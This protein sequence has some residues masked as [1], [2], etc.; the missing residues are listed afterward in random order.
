MIP[1]I[2]KQTAI[3]LKLLTAPVSTWSP[4]ATA[5]N[6]RPG[7]KLNL[8]LIKDNAGL[9]GIPELRSHE[10]FYAM[11]ERAIWETDKLVTE[12]CSPNRTRKL[13]EIFDELSD[14]LCKVADLAEFVRIAHPQAAYSQAAE[15]ACVSISGIVE[16]LNTHQ[17]LY[18]TLRTGVDAGDKIPMSPVDQHVARLFLFDFEQSGIHL[19]ETDRRRVVA[20]NDSILQLGQR[21]ITGAVSPR[22]IPKDSLPPNLRQF[23]SVD[24]D[25]VL[26]T[27]LYADSP[28][29]MAREAA[30]RI[31]LH[32][33]K[34]QEYLL[35]EMLSSRHELAQLCGFPTFSHRA[36][37]ASTAET[38]EM[39]KEFLE[40]MA[41]QLHKR[42]AADFD[43]MKKRKIAENPGSNGQNL[44]PWDTPYY[45]Q[46]VKRDWLQVGSSEFTPYFSLGTCMEG[47]N[48]LMNNLYNISLVN[49]EL[50]PGE[51][52]APDVHKLAVIHEKE[53]LLGHI[54]CD[55][56]ERPGKP[57]QD[58]HF[59]IRGGKELPDGTY[60]NPVVVL[61]LNLPT[62]CRSSPSLLTPGM[63]DNLFHEMGHAMH[64]MLART[65]Y[66]HVT[67]TRCTTDFAEVPSVLMEYF[68]ADPRVVRTF[69]RHYETQ[70]CMPEDMLMRLCASKHL[71]AASDMQVQVFYSA[72][73]QQYHGSHPMEGS[74][75]DVLAQLQKQYYGIPYVPNTAWQLR[76]S[77]L[78][79]Y[80]AKY[81]SY[82][83]SRAVAAWIWQMY[84]EA[85]PLNSSSGEQYRQ[86]C[87]AHGGGKPARELV[88]DFLGR[89]VTPANLANS[90]INEIDITNEHINRIWQ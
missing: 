70:Q 39:V 88:A 30:Y 37:K 15:D 43:I 81:Y 48:N 87:L 18:R 50:A 62:P 6:T 28:N 77:H 4:L 74:T 52:W 20:L 46:K 9:F 40:I 36:L 44:A 26:V 32:P 8:N 16:K 61:M 31:F 78:V 23:F 45:T 67:G 68:V 13:V 64:S 80:G 3:K 2:R 84:F 11:K 69:A 79:G 38:P 1:I 21:F 59:T 7:W 86:E 57:N 14:T 49:D 47:L 73:D 71:F 56:Y 76:F 22:A 29:V 83:L 85:D 5:F 34:H 27:G 72:L 53:G 63:V 54:Y 55:F 10:G 25:Q 19:P 90:L 12:S 33:D 60:Q 89:E 41:Q 58:C 35:S 66:Q 24:G 42:A 75:T 51:I 82:L 17:E 65:R